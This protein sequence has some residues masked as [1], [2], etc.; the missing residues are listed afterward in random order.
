MNFSKQKNLLALNYYVENNGGKIVF[1]LLVMIAL[2]IFLQTLKRKLSNEKE[3]RSDFAGQL[4]FRYPIYSA[5]F[6]GLNLLQFLFK[7]TPFIFSMVFWIL[8]AFC[9]TIIFMGIYF[10]ILEYI[11][12]FYEFAFPAYLYR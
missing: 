10:K 9:L 6:I 4:V 12:A 5:I 2:G 7:D 8:S 1:S 11:L 3:L